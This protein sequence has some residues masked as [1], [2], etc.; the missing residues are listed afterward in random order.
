MV[1]STFI[2]YLF[3][4]NLVDNQKG[5]YQILFNN[6]ALQIVINTKQP[7]MLLLMYWN[8]ILFYPTFNYKPWFQ[9]VCPRTMWHSFATSVNIVMD[10]Q[11]RWHS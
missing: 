6:H 7:Q 4:V 9:V 8:K 2:L 5:H 10:S 11:N 3:P 1:F